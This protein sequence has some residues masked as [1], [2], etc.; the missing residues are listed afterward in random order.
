[1]MDAV[2]KGLAASGGPDD[3]EKPNIKLREVLSR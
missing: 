2:A 3:L 1:M